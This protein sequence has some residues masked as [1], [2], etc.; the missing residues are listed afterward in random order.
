MVKSKFNSLF[1]PSHNAILFFCGG[2]GGGGE[3]RGGVFS[4]KQNKVFTLGT[5]SCFSELDT[6]V[7]MQITPQNDLCH[8]ITNMVLAPRLKE[9]RGGSSFIY[10][11]GTGDFT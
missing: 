2:G 10:P 11:P 1:P 5:V 9:F 6:I 3:V 4:Q 7:L 8:G